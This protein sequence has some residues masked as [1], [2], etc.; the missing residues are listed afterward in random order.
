MATRGLCAIEGCGKPA[1]L[2]AWCGAHYQRWRKYGNPIAGGPKVSPAGAPERWMRHH[3]GYKRDDCLIW[4]FGRSGSG[5]GMIKIRGRQVGAHREMCRR[6]N[7]EPPTPTHEA[8]HSCGNGK[9]GCVN[10]LHLY[11]GTGVDNAQDRWEHGTQLHGEAA[12]TAKLTAD[13]VATI[14]A[15]KGVLS[16]EELAGRYGVSKGTIGCIMSGRTWNWLTGAVSDDCARARRVARSLERVR[17]RA[18]ARSFSSHGGRR[19]L[20]DDPIPGKSDGGGV[21]TP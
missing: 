11:W 9:R 2:R 1:Q 10:R 6:A 4:P 8:A 12:I 17:R 19:E 16:Q 15:Q 5:Y 18:K 13:L 21:A 3:Q 20:G 7:G 14:Y